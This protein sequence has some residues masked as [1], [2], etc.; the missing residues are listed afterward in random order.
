MNGPRDYTKGNK[1]KR[2]RQ[3]HIISM[4]NIEKSDTSK[5]TYKMENRLRH[6]KQTYGS[7]QEWG[8]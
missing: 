1:S 8:G 7:K 5:L 2:E 6:R 4:W 3:I